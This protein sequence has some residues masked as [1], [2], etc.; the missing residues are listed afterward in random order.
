[1]ATAVAL[2]QGFVLDGGEQ[3]QPAELPQGFVLEQP[4]SPLGPNALQRFGQSAMQNIGASIGSA[5]IVGPLLADTPQAR[6]M[7][8]GATLGFS[9]ELA[10][11]IGGAPAKEDARRALREYRQERPVEATLA[12][13]VG[14][15]VTGAVGVGRA[16]AARAAQGLGAQM[17]AGAGAGLAQGGA[18]GFGAGEGGLEERAP[19][20]AFGAAGGAL[21]GGLFPA[22]ASRVSS[23]WRARAGKETAPE[24]AKKAFTILRDA[25][26]KDMGG[27]NKAE[28]ALRNWVRGGA[29]PESLFERLGPEAQA[30]ASEM[31]ARQPT[32]ALAFISRMKDAQAD[33]I[34]GA[35]GNSIKGAGSTKATRVMLEDVRR[36]QAA[37]LYDKAMARE[38]WS[39]DLDRLAQSR[40]EIQQAI[41]TAMR[42]VA[43]RGN[44]VQSESGVPSME[45]MDRAKGVMDDR[46]GVLLRRGA[47]REAGDIIAA[48]NEFVRLLDEANP[49]YA[50]ARRV[51]AGTAEVENAMEA[52]GKF[53]SQKVTADDVGRELAGM[54]ESQREFYKIAVAE[55]FEALIDRTR[56]VSNKASFIATRQM[57]DKIRVLFDN[58]QEA[59]EFVNLLAKSENRF[60]RLTAIDQGTGSQTAARLRAKENFEMAVDGLPRRAAIAIAENP[61]GAPGK[62]ARAA[63]RA[64][65][66]RQYD[67]VSGILARALFEGDAAP[68]AA[69]PNPPLG[70]RNPAV[71]S[72]VAL[73]N[74]QNRE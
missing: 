15:G 21:A 53:L 51:W 69:R 73:T 7:R 4:A 34:R 10:G 16:S 9:D 1:M 27:K 58:P 56:D 49:D 72:P 26:A 63:F 24:D 67:S 22:L 37:P 74:A 20:A 6:A 32:P 23:F 3:G 59:E 57:R 28:A 2:P 55:Q 33:E 62:A 40:P 68:M 44:A 46:I 8:Q 66:D 29:D 11:V 31:A 12:E 71:N 42:R 54:S 45:V 65:S 30:L 5:P 38:A 18:Y 39:P 60:R 61:V 52:G 70:A 25:M 14:G 48:K 47:K 41:K 35:I 50:E 13:L 17:R 43:N 36:V 64:M 19:G